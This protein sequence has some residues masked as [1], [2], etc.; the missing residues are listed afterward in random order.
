[1]NASAFELTPLFRGVI[2]NVGVAATLFG[3]CPLR[4]TGAG[5]CQIGSCGGARSEVLDHHVRL[6]QD[7]AFK[8]R[9]SLQIL[10]VERQ[11][12]LRAAG[13]DEVRRQSPYALVVSAGNVPGAGTFDLDDAGSD[14][15]RPIQASCSSSFAVT[16]VSIL[17]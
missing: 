17:V 1:M 11:A 2:A 14:S 13:P 7:Q 8:H 12:F 6:F 15:L 10:H 4:L 9:R 5:K 16:G 3:R